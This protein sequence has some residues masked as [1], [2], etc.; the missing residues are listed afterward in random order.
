[1]AE[2]LS[3][4]HIKANYR[5]VALF[6]I[7]DPHNK[8]PRQITEKEF[9]ERGLRNE[10]NANQALGGNYSQQQQAAQDYLEI[11]RAHV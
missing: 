4:G 7:D 5:G 8:A 2:S 9:S 11:G 1:M 6:V 3:A 10:R